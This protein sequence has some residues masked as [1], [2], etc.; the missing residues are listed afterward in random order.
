MGGRLAYEPAALVVHVI[1]G[2]RVTRRYLFRRLYAQGRSDVRVGVASN[3]E[4]RQLDLARDALS[5]ALLRGWR[6]DVRRISQ[7]GSRETE[8][9][10][11]VAGR[12][13]QLG[14]AHEAIAVSFG[15]R[16]SNHSNWAGGGA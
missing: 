12:A 3:Q 10:D 8:V 1:E 5:R 7:S 15:G 13:K 6:S 11:I 9:V 2:A 14:I 4:G 16:R